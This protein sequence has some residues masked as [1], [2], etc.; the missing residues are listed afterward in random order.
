MKNTIMFLATILCVFSILFSNNN[1]HKYD[2]IIPG[3]IFQNTH[4]GIRLKAF[5]SDLDYAWVETDSSVAL[6]TGAKVIWQYNHTTPNAKPYFFPV[7]TTTGHNLVWLRPEDHPWHYGLWFSWKY[8]NKLNYWEE[9]IIT[10]LA[11][12]K[13]EINDVSIDLRKDFSARIEFKMD[14]L[15]KNGSHLLNETRVLEISPPDKNGNYYI[16]WS[17]NFKANSEIVIFDRTLP[18]KDGGPVWGGYAG[19]SYR[20]SPQMT[21]HIFSDSKN[22]INKDE[23]IGHGKKAKW[24]DLTGTF[25]KD[26]TMSGMTMFNHPQNGGPDLPWYIFKKGAFAFYNAGLLFNDPKRMAP[27]GVLNLKYRV[28]VHNNSMTNSEINTYYTDYIEK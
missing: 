3:F 11:E 27:N 22:W 12:G 14:Y 2:S 6:L 16:D 28:L 17:L 23:L 10:R 4:N 9:N 18:Q 20:A 15:A 7:N 1:I 25:D 19:L 5:K 24:M 26:G 13:Q 8:I 21:E